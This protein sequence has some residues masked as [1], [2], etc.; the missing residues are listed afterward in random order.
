MVLFFIVCGH[1]RDSPSSNF[2]P[3]LL[4]LLQSHIG[5][6]SRES[7][8]DKYFSEYCDC[9]PRHWSLATTIKTLCWEWFFNGNRFFIPSSW[10]LDNSFLVSWNEMKSREPTTTTIN[11]GEEKEKEEEELVPARKS[12]QIPRLLR[13]FLQ[14]LYLQFLRN[15]SSSLARKKALHRLLLCW[16]GAE[17]V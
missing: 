5:W 8:T 2:S 9:E 16:C 4:L 14:F 7:S 10:L 17:P 15:W 3:L 13:I 11:R 6:H 1:S 12:L